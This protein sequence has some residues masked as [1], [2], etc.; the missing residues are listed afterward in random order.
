MLKIQNV[1][2]IKGFIVGN[3]YTV[4]KMYEDRAVYRINLNDINGVHKKDLRL[5]RLSVKNLYRLTYGNLYIGVP[6]DTIEDIN[7]FLDVIDNLIKK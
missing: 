3:D 6:K 1:E 7:S 5:N 2:K 4:A